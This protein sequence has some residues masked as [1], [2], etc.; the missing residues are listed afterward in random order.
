[1]SVYPPPIQ[2]NSIFNPYNYSSLDDTLTRRQANQTYLIKTGND[3]DYG[4]LTMKQPIYLADGSV[5]SPA[6]SFLNSVQSGWY[7]LSA[8]AL[9][10][11]IG[12]INKFTWDTTTTTSSQT[13]ISTSYQVSNFGGPNAAYGNTTNTQTGMYFPTSTTIGFV[14]NGTYTLTLGTGQ[15]IPFNPIRVQN[16][17]S[18]VPSY[19]FN[20]SADSG[21]YLLAPN[22]VGMSIGTDT[23][24]TWEGKSTKF[25]GNDTGNNIG[26]TPSGFGHYEEY[27]D[28]SMTWNF[29]NRTAVASARFTRIGRQVFFQT[30]TIDFSIAPTT[31]ARWFSVTG[32][33]VQRFRPSSVIGFATSWVSENA[34]VT[35]DTW[36]CFIDAAGTITCYKRPYTVVTTKI[37]VNGFSGTWTI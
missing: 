21:L 24:Q 5:S 25:W 6:L 23:T 37:Y 27:A 7:R 28:F 19:S 29:D 8:T 15:I 14:Q 33:A 34:G 35:Y 11:S 26:Y 36:S 12:G 30:Q 10:L 2:I 16:G 17:S 20:N 1:M 18:V 31:G 32:A 22:Y 4:T 3:T 9:G 13:L